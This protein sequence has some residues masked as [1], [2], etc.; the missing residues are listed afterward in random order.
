[1]QSYVL[2]WFIAAFVRAFKTACQTA[3][4]VIGGAAVMGEVDWV[5]VGS[6]ALLA[7]VVSILTSFAGLPEVED[8]ASLSRLI[9][10]DKEAK[11]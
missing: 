11:Q 8:G 2:T 3:V 7:A 5:L 4:A 9:K 6:S 1:M 10:S